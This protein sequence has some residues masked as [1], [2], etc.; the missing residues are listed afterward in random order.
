MTA[1]TPCQE[2]VMSILA[3]FIALFNGD[4][5]IGFGL[6]LMRQAYD[7]RGL[8]VDTMLAAAVAATLAIVFAQ[9]VTL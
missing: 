2:F 5:A 4:A 1:L 7:G 9:R 3:L 8:R 6:V